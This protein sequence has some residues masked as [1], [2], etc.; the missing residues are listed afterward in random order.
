MAGAGFLAD[1]RLRSSLLDAAGSGRGSRAA[2]GP[3][4]IVETVAVTALSS[5]ETTFIFVIFIRL[6]RE[7]LRN[8]FIRLA[9]SSV[10]HRTTL[11]MNDAAGQ[12]SRFFWFRPCERFLRR[13]RR[14]WPLFHR[15]SKP[16]PL[17]RHRILAAVRF[18]LRPVERQW[19]SI[20]AGAWRSK[21][22]PSF[23]SSKPSSG[24]WSSLGSMATLRDLADRR[25]DLGDILVVVVGHCRSCVVDPA[26]GLSCRARAARGAA[27]FSRCHLWRPVRAATFA[28]AS[29]IRKPVRSMR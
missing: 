15:R 28:I 7:D 29:E 3:F 4:A 21:P 22:W 17:G 6:Q 12:L 5:L 14:R 26:H 19:F 2:R 25:R 16:D 18:L 9:G 13:H 24:R 27:G 10:L 20:R 8:R 11:A 23:L 1:H